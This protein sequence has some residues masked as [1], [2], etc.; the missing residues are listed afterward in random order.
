MEEGK[1]IKVTTL[2]AVKM[3]G[4]NAGNLYDALGECI[5]LSMREN[6]IVK[7]RTKEA[8]YYIDPVTIRDAIA[9]TAKGVSSV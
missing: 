6:K 8:T 1:S 3:D 4:G 5:V 9:S 7:L 2:E